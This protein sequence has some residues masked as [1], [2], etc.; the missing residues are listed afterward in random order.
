VVLPPLRERTAELEDLI[1]N[2]LS[3]PRVN[4]GSV[5]A[6][7]KAAIDKIS[8]FQLAG[9]FRELE[10]VLRRAAQSAVLVGDK[11]IRLADIKGTELHLRHVEA[12]FCVPVWE[13]EGERRY[14]LQC[15]QRWNNNYHFIGGHLDPKLDRSFAEAAA[16]EFE[17][18][19]GIPKSDFT[20]CRPPICVDLIQY[21]RTSGTKQAYYFELY[22][23][24]FGPELRA[25]SFEEPR[26]CWATAEQIIDGW[27]PNN[28]PISS[29]SRQIL[30]KFASQFRAL[31]ASWSP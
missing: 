27:G 20:L 8:E 3:L 25:D 5:T 26:Y 1:L 21:S 15:N 13:K 11:A 24:S 7:T 23:I 9:N 16:R 17:E 30:L 6:I 4:G 2:S 19:T 31:A 14:L 28:R 12:A 22:P 10:M 29:A 18:K